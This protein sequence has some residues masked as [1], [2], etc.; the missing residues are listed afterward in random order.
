MSR[1]V[2]VVRAVTDRVLDVVDE[3]VWQLE[4]RQA[5]RERHVIPPGQEARYERREYLR[6]HT[7]RDR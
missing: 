2:D 4:Q 3:K 1:P 5:F 6:R 7:E